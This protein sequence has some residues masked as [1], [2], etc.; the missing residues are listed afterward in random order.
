MGFNVKKV[1]KNLSGEIFIYEITDGDETIFL[2]RSLCA[3]CG[4]A[5]IN[6]NNPILTCSS[7]GRLFNQ[8]YAEW[9]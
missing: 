1:K 8:E 6:H 3:K 9:E 7:C 4:F 2:H 5:K